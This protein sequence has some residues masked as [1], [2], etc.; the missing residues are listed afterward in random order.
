MRVL[1]NITTI[2]KDVCWKKDEMKNDKE[3]N[4]KNPRKSRKKRIE[5]KKKGNFN[6]EANYPSTICFRIL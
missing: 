4:Y 5:R 6:K 3:V 1:I 2:Q